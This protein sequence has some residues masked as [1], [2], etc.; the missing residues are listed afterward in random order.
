MGLMDRVQNAFNAFMN[1]DPT[2]TYRDVGSSWVNRPD[3]MRFSRGNERSIVTSIYN[4]IA[5]DAASIDLKHVIVDDNDRFIDVVKDGLNNCISFSAN[6]DQTGRAFIQDAVQS[7]L[8]DGVVA[9]VP[10]DTDINPDRTDSYDILT[11]RTAKILEW[12]PKHIKIRVYNDRRGEKED[13]IVPKEKSAIIENPFYAVMNEHSSTMHR[14][15]RK[16]NIL[17]A[18]DEQSGAG[19]LDLI[20]QLPYVIKT[21]ARK[22]QA[23]ERRKDIE[24]QLAGSKYGIAYTD[25][26]EKI[27]QLNRS[28][29]NNLLSQIEYLTNMVYSQLGITTTILD[30]TADEKT[31]NNYYTRTIEPILSALTEEMNR[32]FLST[33][34]RT[35]GHVVKY[36]RNPFRLV[37]ATQMADLADRLTRNEI[38]TSNEV[39]QIMGM[40]PSSEPNA[41]ELRNK[42]ISAPT[43]GATAQPSSEEVSTEGEADTAPQDQEALLESL[44]AQ[45]ASLDENDAKLAEFEKSLGGSEDEDDEDE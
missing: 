29:E 44:K 26:T 24:N 23:E 7:M 36:F 33:N 21:D 17:D 18:I 13:I 10:I 32:K 38:L 16:L 1:K 45:I 25:G 15:I 41:D 35:R 2:R 5:V 4:R 19:K 43:N 39:R 30:G 9:L 3:R 40:K 20:I 8:D 37:A 28:V 31:F 34:A 14:L 11:M 12:Y 6:I 22:K 42:N 27:Q